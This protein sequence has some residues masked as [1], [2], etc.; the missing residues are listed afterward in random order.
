MEVALLWE[1]CAVSIELK[2][3]VGVVWNGKEKRDR[4][5]GHLG[6]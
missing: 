1:T 2:Q 3:L 6:I 5:E 4:N